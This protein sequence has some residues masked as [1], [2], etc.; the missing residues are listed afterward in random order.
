MKGGIYDAH[1]HS[2]RETMVRPR[3]KQFLVAR[4]GAKGRYNRGCVTEKMISVSFITF[5]L[6]ARYFWQ[7]S[8]ELRSHMTYKNGRI[9][10]V[11]DCR[12][13]Q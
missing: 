3:V 2:S 12:L 10:V 5:G 6:P 4:K 8:E 11:F 13:P 1:T 7:L 9:L